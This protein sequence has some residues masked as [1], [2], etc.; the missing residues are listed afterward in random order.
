MNLFFNDLYPNQG[1]YSTATQTIPEA[2]DK[3]VL[4]DDETASN[5]TK[6][7]PKE[8]KNIWIILGIILVIG[9]LLG[10]SK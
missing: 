10:V 2:E 9:I 5:N 1:I 7:T 6:V 3:K 8:R 4:T